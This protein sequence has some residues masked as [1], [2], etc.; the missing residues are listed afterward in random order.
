METAGKIVKVTSVKKPTRKKT[1]IVAAP[2]QTLKEIQRENVGELNP[3]LCLRTS[4]S[5]C[6]F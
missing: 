5:L 4:V 2:N 1:A 6:F 3:P